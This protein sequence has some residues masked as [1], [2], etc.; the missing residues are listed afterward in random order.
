M[1]TR[2]SF[3]ADKLRDYSKRLIEGQMS[4]TLHLEALENANSDDWSRTTEAT[5]TGDALTLQDEMFPL[6]STYSQFLQI[7]ENTVR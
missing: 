5:T 2:S 1:L 4:Q 3:L 7:L 6:V